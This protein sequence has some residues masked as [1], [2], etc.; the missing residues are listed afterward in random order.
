MGASML[1]VPRCMA[2]G[3]MFADFLTE[4]ASYGYLI[5]SNGNPAPNTTTTAPKGGSS[6]PLAGLLGAMGSGMSKVQMLTDSIDWVTKGSAA[7]YGEIDLAHLA[8]AGQSCGGLEG[9][10]V[11]R[12]E[13]NTS[14]S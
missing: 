10:H 9:K 5:L 7:K 14:E 2:S 1:I 13:C 3:T 11:A 4:I 6:N 8:A 12:A